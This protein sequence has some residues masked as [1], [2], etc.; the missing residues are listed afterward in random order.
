MGGPVT[1]LKLR[2]VD[3]WPDRHGTVRYYFRRG[4]GARIALPGEPGT[5]E[6]MAAYKAAFS[7]QPETLNVGSAKHGAGTLSALAIEYFRS[8]DF[9]RLQS[10]TQGNKRRI[11]ERF[12][13]G[14]GHRLVAQM[15]RE[16]VSRIIGAM[17]E[18]PAAANNLLKNL[19]VLMGFAIVNN[20][21][22]DDPTAKIKK[23]REGEFH[24]WTEE[25][26]KVFE[27][28]WPLGSRERTAYALHLYTGQRRS[29]VFRM[30]WADIVDGRM[31]VVQVKGGGKLLI[32]MHPELTKALERW[33]KSHVNII[34]SSRGAPYT[35]ESY[36][37]LMSDSIGAAG[38]PEHCVL[39]GLRKA[40]ARRLA[41]AGCTEKQI[42]A[43]T[44]HKT[45]SEVARYTRAA[46]QSHLADSAILKL[47][48]PDRS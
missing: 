42:A 31:R 30:T 18:T 21:R 3:R 39:H 41:E 25:E 47:Q 48:R 14:N 28:R 19:R 9:L 44:G 23:F 46:E 4:H 6:F 1:F 12:L 29:D 10:G 35:V 16:H 36:G 40:A 32:P 8:A 7:Q 17:A 11:L 37:N 33:P 26:L 13:V 24:T 43:I 27:D 22:V 38:V 15:K 2:H 20:W 5:E 34:V 45:L